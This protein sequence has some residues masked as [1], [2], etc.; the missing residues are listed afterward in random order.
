MKSFSLVIFSVCWGSKE[1]LVGF[2]LPTLR[3]L[4]YPEG[5]KRK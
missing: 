2:A 4:I 5:V 3:S 1:R